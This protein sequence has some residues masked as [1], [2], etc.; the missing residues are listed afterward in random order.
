MTYAQRILAPIDFSAMSEPA[1]DHAMALADVFGASV[2]LL[3]AHDMPTAM[4]AIVPGAHLETD[5]AM[6]RSAAQRRLDHLAAR[7]RHHGFADVRVALV[8]GPPVETILRYATEGEFDLI[9]MGT[10]G[11]SGLRR[12]LIGSVAEGVLRKAHCPVVTVHLPIVE[13]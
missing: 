7:L 1:V 6:I 13:R 11:R 8:A 12:I 9:V 2:T 10:H 4:G 3:H 5:L